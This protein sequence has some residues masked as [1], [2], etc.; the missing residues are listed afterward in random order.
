MRSNF[1]IAIVA[2]VLSLVAVIATHI[3]AQ[4]AHKLQLKCELRQTL[5]TYLAAYRD[6]LEKISLNGL[7]S[8]D[9]Y[10]AS[11]PEDKAQVQIVDGFLYQL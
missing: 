10:R 4:D 11:K 6:T 8:V 7:W 1:W 2:A 9:V 5:V 3:D